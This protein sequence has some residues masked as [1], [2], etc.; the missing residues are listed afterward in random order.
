MYSIGVKRVM[1]MYIV[2]TRSKEYVKSSHYVKVCTCILL[3]HNP[4]HYLFIYLLLLYKVL[5][6]F[7]SV[8]LLSESLFLKV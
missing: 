7:C 4:H 1:V 6:Y 5:F 8:H 2:H 3:Y